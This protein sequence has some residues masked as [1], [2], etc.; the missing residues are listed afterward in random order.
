MYLYLRCLRYGSKV[1]GGW[2]VQGR[3][4]RGVRALRGHLGELQ[5]PMVLFEGK[6]CI[7]PW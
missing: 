7:A 4:V 1:L 2:W 6:F 3:R 5:T